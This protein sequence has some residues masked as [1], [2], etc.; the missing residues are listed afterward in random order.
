MTLATRLRLVVSVVVVSL[1]SFGWAQ[2]PPEAGQPVDAKQVQEAIEQGIAYLRREQKP[3]GNWNELTTYPGPAPFKR[4]HVHAG[5][6]M[7]LA[8]RMTG[9]LHTV[10]SPQWQVAIWVPTSAT[11]RNDARSSRS[12]HV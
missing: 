9:T 2:Q 6:F 12:R 7:R 4:V 10:R 3:R 5:P 8:V 1:V 11:A